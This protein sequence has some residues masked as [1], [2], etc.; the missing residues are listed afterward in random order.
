MIWATIVVI[1]VVV[2]V[3][4]FINWRMQPPPPPISPERAVEAPR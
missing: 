2:A 4:L 3:W 1:A